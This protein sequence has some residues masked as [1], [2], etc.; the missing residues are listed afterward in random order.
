MVKIS[1]CIACAMAIVSSANA[2]TFNVPH[3]YVQIQERPFPASEH[4]TRMVR[5][6]LDAGASHAPGAFS[7][8][9]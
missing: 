7:N 5:V 6:G 9:R 4:M 1:A 2:Q 3:F 8:R